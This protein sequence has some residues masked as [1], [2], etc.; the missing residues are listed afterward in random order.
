MTLWQEIVRALALLLIIEGILPFLAPRR[1]RLLLLAA[2]SLEAR[3][4]RWIALACLFAGLVL[5]QWQ[6]LA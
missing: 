6:R 5:L 4:L 1:F 3:Q 2:A